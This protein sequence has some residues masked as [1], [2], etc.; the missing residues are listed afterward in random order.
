MAVNV[1]LLDYGLGNILSVT[2]ALEFC[3]AEVNI[4]SDP[5][6][7]THASKIILPGVG[8]FRHAMSLL[9]EKRLDIALRMA[10]ANGSQLMGICLGMQLLMDSSSEFGFTK[11]LGFIPGGVVSIPNSSPSGI[12]LKIPHIGWSE[13]QKPT[14]GCEWAGSMLGSTA[15]GASVYFVHSFMASP[16]NFDDVLADCNYGGVTVTAAIKR[17]NVSGVQFHPEKSGPA[18]LEILRT[19]MAVG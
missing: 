6:V 2:R 11:G 4:T 15:T 12:I 5:E 19:F 13:L 8:A 7:V 10:V 9:S 1:T 18:G 14:L 3:G 17:G 16:H